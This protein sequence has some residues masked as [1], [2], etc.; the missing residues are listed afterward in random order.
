MGITF[1]KESMKK[2]ILISGVFTL[3]GLGGDEAENLYE[4][5]IKM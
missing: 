1:Y 3:E 2:S 5:L 4:T